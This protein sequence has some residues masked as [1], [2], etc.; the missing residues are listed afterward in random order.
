LPNGARYRVATDEAGRTATVTVRN[1]RVGARVSLALDPS[2]G[3]SDTFEALSAQPTEHFLGGG[4]Q[5]NPLDLHGQTIV[6][7]V[8]GQCFRGM[9]SPFYISSAGYGISLRTS[10]IA[11][12]GFPGASSGSACFASSA[13]RCPLT[14]G[15][16]VVQVCTESP[17]LTYDVFAGA[18]DQIISAYTATTSRPVLPP[19]SQFALMKWRDLVTGP[20]QLYEDINQLHRARIP[21]GWVVLDNPWESSRCFGRMTFD[22]SRFPDPRAMI[23]TIHGLGVRFM[24]WISPLVRRL[25]CTPPPQYP[26]TALLGSGSNSTLDLTDPAVVSTFESSLRALISLGVDGFKGDRGNDVGFENVQLAGGP[27]ALVQNIYPLLYERAVAAAI[28]NSGKAGSFATL[29]HVGSPGSSA[30]VPGF[31]GGDQPGTFAGL[32]DA[33]RDGLS[34]GVAGYPTW[35]SDTGGFGSDDLTPEVFVR[36]AQFS[37]VSP[38]FEVGGTGGNATF[39]NFGEPTVSQFRA[40]AILHYELFPYLYQDARVAHATGLPILRPLALDYPQDAEAW[41][42]DL[43]LMVGP[44]VLALPVTAPL[45]QPVDQYFPAG[46][47]VSLWGGPDVVGPQQLETTVPLGTLPLYL[48]AGSAVPFD[49]RTP[50][51][52]SRP[53][54]VNDLDQP[55]RIGW[56][57]AP[58]SGVTHASSSDERFAATT[59]A[60][61]IQ[62]TVTGRRKEVELLVLTPRVPRTVLVDGRTA[63]RST[64]VGLQRRRCGWT[65]T[66]S[67]FHGIVVKLTTTQT[68]SR[69]TIGF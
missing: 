32:Q 5:S 66:R 50:L 67:R 34:A 39:W 30:V 19:V 48:R 3:V 33:I 64:L 56:V 61:E 16:D 57:Y 4:E 46:R 52:W 44:S 49:F 35:G 27:G 13:T 28:E 55:G 45:G 69:V 24:L 65:L 41:A 54:G 68:K 22:Q 43:E 21:I 1:T 12:I 11:A 40:A 20:D 26:L 7:D 60:R 47:W 63:A 37:A 9:S 25:G 38:V 53:W 6:N 17:T 36:W 29:F 10:A 58:A 51:V 62:V 42:A 23:D 2:T 31:W 14:S 15:L 18:P 59:A 8:S